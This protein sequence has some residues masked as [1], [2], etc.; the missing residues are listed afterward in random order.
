MSV[1]AGVSSVAIPVTGMSC[2]NS[3]HFRAVAVSSY[4]TGAGVDKTFATAQC[5]IPDPVPVAPVIS[6][7]PKD[8]APPNRQA[9]LSVEAIGTSLRYQ[10]YV[11]TTG[12][13]TFPIAGA[14]GSTY[15]TPKL[16]ATM[17]FWVRVS[18]SAGTADSRTATVTIKNKGQGQ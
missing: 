16:T 15:Q 9:T 3:Y 5:P 17:S 1:A 14:T 4:G 2:G 7:Q 13:T 10:W 6:L 8:E 18:N 11:G 12:V